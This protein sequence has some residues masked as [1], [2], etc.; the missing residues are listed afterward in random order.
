MKIVVPPRY[1]REGA[2]SRYRMYN[3]VPPLESEGFTCESYEMLGNDY[4]RRRY[5]GA[6]RRWSVWYIASAYARRLAKVIRAESHDLIWLEK[7]AFP[8]LPSWFESRLLRSSTPYVVDYDDPEFHN[9]DQHPFRLVR[10]ILGNKI[11]RIMHDAALVIVGNQYLAD[12]AYACASRRV[13]ILPTVVDLAIYP[14]VPPPDNEVFTIGWIG[15]PIT[16]RFLQL[17]RPSLEQLCRGGRLR[18]SAIGAGN[19][20]LGEVPLE[21]R[22]FGLRK[23]RSPIFNESMS[24]SCL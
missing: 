5:A 8:Y 11:D 14:L 21:I 13:E 3:Y 24:G 1:S 15:T 18:A 4:L 2:S 7:E 17:V 9:Y 23:R 20:E 6:G 12:R 22:P 16:S 19:L 10:K